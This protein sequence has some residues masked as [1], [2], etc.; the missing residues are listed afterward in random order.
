MHSYDLY[1]RVLG[2]LMTAGIGDALGAPA[3]GFSRQEIADTFGRIVKFEDA[4][5]NAISP[6]NLV[7]EVTDDTS[8]MIE[9]AK[10][11]IRAG[12][13]LTV[14]GAGQALLN[15]S[16]NWPKYYPRNA[17]GTTKHVI[18]ALERGEDPVRIG[19][20]GKLP[21]RGATNGAVMRVAAAGLIHPGDL[22]GA[23]RTAIT[24]TVPSHGT[25]HGFGGACAVACA[26]AGA[27]QESP[28]V[29]QVLKAAVY[30]AKQG[31]AY[32]ERHGRVAQGPS[33]AYKIAQAAEA[34]FS[35]ATRE[36]AEQR[37][38]C[39]VGCDSYSVQIT[40]A[41]VLGMFAAADGDTGK[42]LESCANIGG[43]TDTFGCVAGMIAGAFNGCDGIPQNLIQPFQQ[44]N[45][46]FDFQRLAGEL[47]QI[48]REN[49]PQS[50]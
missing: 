7:G 9:M 32:G 2:S 13:N 31:Q 22:D 20:L 50:R 47:T 16:R 12:G 18:L 14:D 15:W 10:A 17:G 40:V 42:T 34:V 25:Q 38:Q 23:C 33:V 3:E 44:T 5:H 11:V 35:S 37:V 4:S 19:K 24:M 30:G 21:Y 49:I 36:E 39:A 41:V 26:I 1:D 6:D 43:D 46:H 27:M 28:S 45:T 48:A 8:Q 29:W